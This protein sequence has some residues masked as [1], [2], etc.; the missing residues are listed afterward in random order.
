[1]RRKEP[2][3]K[4]RG[5]VEVVEAK[6]IKI[7][8][9]RTQYRDQSGFQLAYYSDGKRIRERAPTIEAARQQAK[10]KIAD[11]TAGTAHV[12]NFT[13]RQV[14]TIQNAVEALQ[15][16]GVSLSDAIQQFT[17]AHRLL[18]GK[19]SLIEAAQQF[20][21]T[22][23]KQEIPRKMFPEVVV[24]FL[25]H[26]ETTGLSPLYR[27]DCR[28]HLE[29]AS[30][31]LR[32]P[33]AAIREDVLEK[34]LLE[35]HLSPRSYNNHRNSLVTLFN[36]AKK[37][38][39]LPRQEKSAPELISKRKDIGGEIQILSPTEYTTL[40]SHTPS[41]FLPYVGLGGLAGLRTAEIARLEWE[42]VDFD[43]GHIV[44]KA[45]K[46]KTAS[47]RIVPICSALDRLLRPIAQKKG[48]IMMYANEQ[49]M[50]NRWSELKAK[51]VTSDGKPA[52]HVPTNALRHSYASYRLALTEDAAKVSLEMGNSP[53]KL[54]QNYRKLVTKR[55]AEHWFSVELKTEVKL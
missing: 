4:A 18:E 33:I 16:V 32:A 48:K 55:Q 2:R 35:S 12:A 39:Y 22:S 31:A 51:M 42:E 15:T 8:I 6:G 13:P 7:P 20:V 11:L 10:S 30:K 23:R 52:V 44:I 40:L 14:A 17:T 49:S 37:R 19:G 27:R 24:E 34:Y 21:Q 26:L 46:A 47:R 5:P 38:G 41:S 28:I 43:E 36:F 25:N 53:R 50:M 45:A 3:T 1:M 29:R 9:Y 54:F